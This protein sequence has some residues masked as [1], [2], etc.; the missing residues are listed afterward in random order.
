MAASL[1]IAVRYQAP[2]APIVNASQ[3]AYVPDWNHPVTKPVPFL[4]VELN[5]AAGQVVQSTW[6]DANGV[7]HFTGL[8]SA[9]TYTPKITS[10]LYI[11]SLGVDFEVVDNTAPVDISQGTFRQ[12]YAPYTATAALY[13]PTNLTNQSL[14]GHGSGW[15]GRNK[16]CA[17]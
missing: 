9:I 15:V 16:C 14:T 11:P 1:D 3:T 7:A 17:R 10:K 8:D 12:R 13:S 5:N 4:F 6:A 2:G